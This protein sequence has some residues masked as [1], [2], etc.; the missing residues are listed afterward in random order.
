MSDFR[1]EVFY[2]VARRLSFT[3]AAA[4]LFI[5]QPAVT[6]HINEL[7]QQ[8]DNKLF[9]RKGNKIQ[10]TAAGELLLSH[11]EAL[12]DVYRNID[13]DM[14]ALV[15]KKEGILYLGASTTVSQ[16]IIAPILAGFRKKFKAIEIRLINGNTE[17][18][19]R[20]LLEKEIQLGIIEGRS[21]HQEISYTEFIR[22][23]IVLVC[24]KDHP[25]ARKSEL[26]KESILES[27]FVMREQGSGTLEVIDYALKEIGM[28]VA[29]LKVEIQLGST[30]S[31]KSYLMHSHCLAFI[32]VHALTDELQRGTLRIIDVAGLNIERYF[33]FIQLHGKPDGLSEVFLRHAQL[34]HN[35]K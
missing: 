6:K 9:E 32:S 25:L 22:D 34:A 1:L 3:K 20:A 2:T 27:S 4:A 15:H 24:G 14:N 31:I 33:Y 19:E 35:L 26:S 8:Y 5:T 21:K 30:E 18:I 10:L 29:D 13:F 23:E 12:F 11:T 7:E 16:Y 17:Q 28:R